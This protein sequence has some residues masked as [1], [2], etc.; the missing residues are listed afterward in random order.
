M[1]YPCTYTWHEKALDKYLLKR[2][3]MNE[4]RTVIDNDCGALLKYLQ[5]LT[6][7]IF[8]KTLEGIPFSSPSYRINWVMERFGNLPHATAASCSSMIQTQS[9]SEAHA[10]HL[11]FNAKFLF[12]HKKADYAPSS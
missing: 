7:S 3:Q 2:K 9:G 8:V 4:W 11:F 10:L 5:V 1:L 6:H 12:F